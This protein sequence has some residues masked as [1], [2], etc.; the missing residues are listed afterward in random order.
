MRRG[1][2]QGMKLT[3]RVWAILF[4]FAFSGAVL[5]LAATARYG[6]GL[7]PDS[8][9]YVSVARNLAAGRGLVPHS[10]SPFVEWPPL[11]PLLL[12]LPAL[13]GIEPI[14]AAR[15]LNAVL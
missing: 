1:D 4:A 7:T 3:R 13:G 12:A 14:A 5:I 6:A 2:M 8:G 9:C 10:G 15:V 11:Y